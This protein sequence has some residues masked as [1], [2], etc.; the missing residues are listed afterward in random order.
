MRGELLRRLRIVGLAI[1]HLR[2]PGV[3]LDP[4]GPTA[5]GMK[6]AADFHEPG[7]PLPAIRP[8]NVRPASSNCSAACSGVAPI[9]VRSR[10]APESNVMQA[11]TGKPA[12][13]AAATARRAS[14]G[15]VMVSTTTASAPAAAIAWACS[16]KAARRSSS[17]TSPIMS[18]APLGPIEA[19][20]FTVS[21]A[22]RR[23]ISTPA[24]LI[25]ATRLARLC[26][27]RIKRL[28]PKVLVR[29]IRLPAAT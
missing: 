20:T 8:D 26:R 28:A 24:R 7:H 9:M 12:W 25:S 11:T 5:C 27:A 14:A 21:A 18:I 3:G 17:L 2:Q 15:S 6:V 1:A 10:R 29:M 4:Y 23:E 22:A 13:W 16:E 19:K